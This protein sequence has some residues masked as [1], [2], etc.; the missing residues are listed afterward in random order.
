[1]QK[2]QH[3]GNEE[4][5]PLNPYFLVYIRDDGT[6]RYNYTNAKQILEVFRL[7]CQR[8]NTPFTQ[9]CELFNKDTRQGSD[10]KKHTELLEK[11]VKKIVE[12][13]KR[14]GNNHLIND[15]GAIL[16]PKSKQVNEMKDFELIT[17]LIVR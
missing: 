8:Q 12:V 9:L 10:M 2:E 5:N 6:V 1:V 4:V 15:R 17:W 16:I 7:L 14:R 13:F 3:D 11:A